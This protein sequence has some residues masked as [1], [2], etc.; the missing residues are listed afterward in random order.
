MFSLTQIAKKFY[1]KLVNR[2]TE[3][4]IN[5]KDY[6]NP[7]IQ[8]KIEQNFFYNLC[9]DF[10]PVQVRIYSLYVAYMDILTQVCIDY[11]LVKEYIYSLYE[12]RAC[13]SNALLQTLTSIYSRGV[14][15]SYISLSLFIIIYDWL[16]HR[17]TNFTIIYERPFYHIADLVIKYVWL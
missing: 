12:A 7:N 8:F 10:S 5:G 2:W 17:I 3:I 15:I 4:V 6:I 1:Q 13:I 9:V 16:Y 14:I 11:N